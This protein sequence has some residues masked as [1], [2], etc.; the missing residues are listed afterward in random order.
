MSLD[1]GALSASTDLNSISRAI[2]G[3]GSIELHGPGMP[4]DFVIRP[5]SMLT[6]PADHLVKAAQSEGYRFVDRLLDEWQSSS[7]CFDDEGEAFI[8]VFASETLMAI[9]G[10]N[11]DPYSNEHVARIRHVYV[12]PEYRRKGVG[13]KLA[14]AL[15]LIAKNHYPRVRLRASDGAAA[16]FYEALG[17]ARTSEADSTH[18]TI[19]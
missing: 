17:F 18:D 9:G 8:G 6:V 10:L 12:L 2:T 5:V 14:A 13:R 1:W 19:I 15:L 16:D 7:N 3:T 4:S 11:R